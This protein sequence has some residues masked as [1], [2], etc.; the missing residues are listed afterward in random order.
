MMSSLINKLYHFKTKYASE[1]LKYPKT[2][3]D[4]EKKKDDFYG[5]N[6]ADDDESIR[7]TMLAYANK[8]REKKSGTKKIRDAMNKVLRDE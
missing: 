3:G 1:A 8:E 2:D 7:N 5:M 6:Y 4:E